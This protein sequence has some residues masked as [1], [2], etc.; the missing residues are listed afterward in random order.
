MSDSLMTDAQQASSDGKTYCKY[1]GWVIQTKLPCN[2]VAMKELA[3]KDAELAEARHQL[4][5][6]R[7]VSHLSKLGKEQAEAQAK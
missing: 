7:A 6:S 1:C 5:L 4:E 3:A 2:C